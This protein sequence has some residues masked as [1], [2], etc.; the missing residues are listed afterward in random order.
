MRVEMRE[1]S[2]QEKEEG[3]REGN[4]R[5]MGKGEKRLI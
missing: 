3:G 1:R 5:G 2:S 4:G